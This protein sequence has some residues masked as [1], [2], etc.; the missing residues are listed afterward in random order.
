[1][2][3]CTDLPNQ[4]TARSDSLPAK[5]LHATSLGIRIAAIPTGTLSFF[6]SHSP[7]LNLLK[8]TE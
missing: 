4:N 3:L 7:I 1:V 2:E 6:M 8:F 5:P